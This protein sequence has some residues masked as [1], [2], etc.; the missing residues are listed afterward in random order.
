MR[1]AGEQRGFVATTAVPEPTSVLG[2]LGLGLFGLSN[3]RKRK[4]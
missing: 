4:K 2:V 1:I 3:W